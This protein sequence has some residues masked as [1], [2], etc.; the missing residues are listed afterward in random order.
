MNSKPSKS[1]LKREA[2]AVQSLGE[3]LL[4]LGDAELARMPLD[5]DV[6]EVVLAT[7]AQRSNSALRRQRL[8]LAKVLRGTDIDALAAAIAGLDQQDGASRRR[9]HDAERWRDRLLNE[10][11]PALVELETHAGG[12]SDTLTAL[13]ERL[14]PAL[15]ERE[16]KRIRR[17]VF[18]EIHALLDARV[19]R[20]GSSG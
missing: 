10:G 17:E 12:S 6:R 13:L 2:K 19:Q 20:D 15:P 1:A 8:Y 18:R 14:G 11:Q 3:R 7:R 4:K 9:F 16:T 5:D